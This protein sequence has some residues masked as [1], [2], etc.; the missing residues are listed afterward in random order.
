MKPRLP[1]PNPA[2]ETPRYRVERHSAPISLHLDGNEGDV[3]SADVCEALRTLDAQALQRYPSAGVL[4]AQIAK[5]Q[6]IDAG[7][8]L[9]TAG[10]DEGLLRICRAFL[11]PDR[12]LVLPVPTFEMIARFAAWSDAEVRRVDWARAPYPTEA[13]L[14]ATCPNTALIAV[15]SPNNPT[16]FV[17][18]ADDLKSLSRAAP[19]TLIM[20]DAAYG[21][22]AD[23]DLV[24]VALG[25]PNAVVFRT[26]SKAWGLAGMRTGYLMGPKQIVDTLRGAG[27]P[28]PVSAPALAAAQASLVHPQSARSYVE[29]VRNRRIELK[30]TL[31]QAGLC[32]ATSQGN[33]VF[34]RT[35]ENRDGRWWR[36]AMAGLGIAVRAWPDD[37]DLGDAIRVTVPATES[38]WDRL[39]HAIQTAADPE[40]LFFDLDGVLADVRDSYRTAILQ[41]AASFGVT[42]TQAEIEAA[43]RL[44]E[45]NN[46]WI[47]TQRLLFERGVEADLNTVQK[48]FE[49]RYQ[50]TGGADGLWKNER[51]LGDRNALR[52]LADTL[53]LAIVT[54]RPR[55]DADRFL[56]QF[57]IR[58]LFSAVITMEDGI[59]PDPAPV[60]KAL[61]DLGV[62]RAW[63]LGDTPDDVRAARGAGVLPIGIPAPGADPKIEN[64]ILLA[65]GAAFVW[66]NWMAWK[67]R[68]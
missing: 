37:A 24:S 61:R 59:K 11:G 32:A 45:A 26:F 66:P 67:E 18:T 50:G 4:E 23:D 60:Q 35:A 57:E 6:G 53:P 48:R 54:G 36:D 22:F 20:L 9:V 34:A 25:L 2:F 29:N 56:D 14:D 63:M 44:G 19:H 33:F 38:D 27:L 51:F 10:G 49:D 28:Y 5:T 15:V 68:R 62:R 39:Q 46:D 8:V 12:N 13:V 30:A 21:E 64:N 42:L 52:S 40:A 7:R 58:D 55:S 43:K 47:L 3:P 31:D 1:R 16:G 41:T 65:A 17:A